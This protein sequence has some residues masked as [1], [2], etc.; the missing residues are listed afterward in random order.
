MTSTFSVPSADG[1]E[2]RAADLGSGPP[3]LIVPPGM[4]DGRGYRRVAAV[5]AQRHRVLILHRR[6][7]RLDLQPPISIKEEVADVLALTEAIEGRPLLF[8]HSSGAVVALECLVAMSAAFSGAALYEP[9]LAIDQLN[10]GPALVR[11][12]HAV[13]QG[14][15]GRAMQIFTHDMVGLPP[16]ASRL[17]GLFVTLNRHMGKMAERQIADV[18]AMDELGFR[19]PSYAR[20]TTPT[21][22]I[23]GDRSPG[24]LSHQLDALAASLTDVTRKTVT[25]QGHSAQMRAPD[26]LADIVATY[27]GAVRERSAPPAH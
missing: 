21:L 15:P 26:R 1:T 13:A 16:V 11:A 12:Q 27:Y 18:A 9:P 4:D 19:L 17:I 3:V 20:V 24:K 23:G 5:L 6:Q 10:G 8:G 22:L 14:K 7:Y 25:G 2:V